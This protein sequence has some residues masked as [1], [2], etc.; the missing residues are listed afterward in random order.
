MAYLK[1]ENIIKSHGTLKSIEFGRP[2]Y[3]IFER[4]KKKHKTAHI[5]DVM[6]RMN[7]T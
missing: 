5:A 4:E 6:Q 2:K 1:T 7:K 3:G